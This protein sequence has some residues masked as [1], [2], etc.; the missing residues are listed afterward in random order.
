MQ[1]SIFGDIVLFFHLDIFCCDILQSFAS[2]V[3]DRLFDSLINFKFFPMFTIKNILF[4]KKNTQNCVQSVDKHKIVWYIFD[5]HKN[6][7]IKN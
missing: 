2:S 6:V 1:K 3:C 5:T 4:F 7:W